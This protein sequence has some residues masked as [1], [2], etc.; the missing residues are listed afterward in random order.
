[1]RGLVHLLLLLGS[2]GYEV[3]PADILGHLDA[4]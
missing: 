2:A 1:M 4:R 3:D